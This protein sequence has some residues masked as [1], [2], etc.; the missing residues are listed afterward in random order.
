MPDNVVYTKEE[1]LRIAEMLIGKTFGELNS[2]KMRSELYNKGSFGHILE[3]DVYKYNANSNSKPDF[4]SAGIELKVTP[5]KINKNGTLS[6]K[7]RLVLNII[8]YM[9]EYRN[10]FY[11]SHFWYKNKLI[12]IVWYLYEENKKKDEFKI[13]HS[14]LFTF[15]EEDLPIIIQDWNTI[16]GKIKA[17][18]A[19]EI[20]EADTMYLGA[21]TKGVNSNSMRKQ[22]FSDIEA[23]QRAFCLKTS[24]MT[25]LVREYIGGER[26]ERITINKNVEKTFEEQLEERLSIYK[27]MTV[28]RLVRQFNIESSA[29]NLNEIIVARMLGVKGRLANTDSFVK[30]NIV[31][32]T[33]RINADGNIKESMSFPT[34]KF[35]KIIQEE[36]E[37][38]ELYNMFATTKFMFAVF[39]EYDGEYHFEKIKFWNMPLDILETEV[40]KVWQ[41]TVDIIKQGNIV[42]EIKDGIRITNFPGM[43]EN[44][45][46]HVRPHAQKASDVYPLPVGDTLTGVDEYT[47]QCFWLNANYILEII[48]KC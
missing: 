48:N 27:G 7:E 36:W 23:K 10:T 14:R 1:V 47:K 25:Q 19:H 4:E 40:K 11:T 2:Y 45:Y 38:S 39:K 34:F 6:A 24:Y 37:E 26:L 3:E 21:C 15:P 5:Y 22:P 30:A 28:S 17:G 43:A 31:P 18:K 20:S 33:I 44:E 9:Q 16:V 13:T 8:N 35:E 46:C 32:K 42:K 29:K 12:E 41:N